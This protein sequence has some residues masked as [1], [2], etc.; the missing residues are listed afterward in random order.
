MDNLTVIGMVNGVLT[1]LENTTRAFALESGFSEDD[2]AVAEQK[3]QAIGLK[4]SI[5]QSIEGNGDLG[6]AASRE[7]KLKDVLDLA[8]VHLLVE[9]VVCG[10]SPSNNADR[11][12]F[13][14]LQELAGGADILAYAKNRL[15][16][17][18]DRKILLSAPAKPG[19]VTAALDDG[20]AASTAFVKILMSKMGGAS[21][22][23]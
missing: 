16:Q 9:I 2:I 3:A 6:D 5:R 18:K 4:Q 17:I 11:L 14:M 7:G 20:F 12:R 22:E 13:T 1:R 15:Q 10:E 8:A 23:P 21:N 19:G